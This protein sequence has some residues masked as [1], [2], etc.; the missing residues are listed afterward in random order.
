MF[1]ENP[2][3]PDDETGELA[4]LENEQEPPDP[5]P[6]Q[7]ALD[8]KNQTSP[9][10]GP[11]PSPG[12]I[13][14][15]PVP[16][17]TRK[18]RPG[19]ASN[20]LYYSKTDPDATV[21]KPRGK[22]YM[23]AYSVHASVDNRANVITALDTTAAAV[24]DPIPAPAMLQR[25]REYHGLPVATVAADT[26]YGRGW[27]YQRLALM[28]IRAYIPHRDY[29][30][31]HKGFWG[32]S[33]FQYDPDEDVYICP[34][35]KKLRLKRYIWSDRQWDYQADAADCRVCTLRPQCT[36][37]KAGRRVL[38]SIYQPYIAEADRIQATP[39]GRRARIRRKTTV[40]TAFGNTK[41]WHRLNKARYRGL[42][43]MACQA[44][45]SATA[46]NLKKL[47]KHQRLVAT[48]AM[49][50]ELHSTGLADALVRRRRCRCFH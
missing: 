4:T 11:A 32:Y 1:A 19:R 26:R 37:N 34:N 41:A 5:D 28:G 3:E 46:Y 35:G 10:H 23:L 50:M 14:L 18:P 21:A 44:L 45:L 29:G 31:V 22:G 25:L 43:K 40:E 38:R 9:K 12:S 2:V 15:S 49:A 8:L 7:S 33:H 13:V 48:A 16:G 39:D 27:F 42:G 6:R 24:D 17:V 20:Q 36:K 30:N 47:L